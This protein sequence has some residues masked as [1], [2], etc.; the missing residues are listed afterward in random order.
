MVCIFLNCKF[1]YF[2]IKVFN[3]SRILEGVKSQFINLEEI[4]KFFKF[5]EGEKKREIKRTLIL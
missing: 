3:I 2:Q 5:F 1:S 4:N